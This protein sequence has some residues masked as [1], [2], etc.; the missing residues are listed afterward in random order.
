MNKEKDELKENPDGDTCRSCGFF[1]EKVECQGIWHCPNALCIGC[2][3]GWFRRTLDSYK[4]FDD[5]SRDHTVDHNEWLHKGIIYNS[6]HGIKRDNFI[7]SK[8]L[9]E[10]DGKNEIMHRELWKLKKSQ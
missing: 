9:E 7:R 1:D 6:E 2:G 10:E 3:G 4:E 8:E 5:G